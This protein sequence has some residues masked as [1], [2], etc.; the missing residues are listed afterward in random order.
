MANTGY[1]GYS[2][3]E[4]YYV[5]DGAATGVTKANTVGQADYVEPVYDTI[6]CPVANSIISINPYSLL[7]N[8]Y[9]GSQDVEIT[10]N[11]DDLSFVSNA[12]WITVF[13]NGSSGNVTLTIAVDYNNTG[14]SRYD[15]VNIYHGSD[16][17][18]SIYVEQRDY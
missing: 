8:P 4:W 5:G 9:S 3:L 1:K 2:N 14:Q 15:D 12:T 16:Y 6:S 18:A 7:F 17:I 13:A 10:S 11:Y